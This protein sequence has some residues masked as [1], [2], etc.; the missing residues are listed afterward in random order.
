MRAANRGAAIATAVD[1]STSRGGGGSG[2][3]RLHGSRK[4]DKPADSYRRAA[5]SSASATREN[6][7]VH[8]YPYRVLWKLR[9]FCK[10]GTRSPPWGGRKTDLPA[11]IFLTIAEYPTLNA[12]GIKHRDIFINRRIRR[13]YVCLHFSP[14]LVLELLNF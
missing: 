6:T 2:E 3:A 13:S 12:T 4:C 9:T 7:H 8:T 14:N 11:I 10:L 5:P 1:I